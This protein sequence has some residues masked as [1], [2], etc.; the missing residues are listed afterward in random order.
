VVGVNINF[1][2]LKHDDFA[3][4][5]QILNEE[6]NKVGIATKVIE[7]PAD[8]DGDPNAIHISIGAKT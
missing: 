7:F 5:A 2:S 6:L 8:D 1:S 3:P 4:A